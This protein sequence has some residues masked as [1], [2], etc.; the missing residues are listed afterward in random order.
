MKELEWV[1]TERKT[2]WNIIF[3]KI[4]VEFIRII[5]LDVLNIY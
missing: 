4:I 5:S 1:K 3:T 2:K